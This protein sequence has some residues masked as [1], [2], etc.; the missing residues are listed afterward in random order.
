MFTSAIDKTLG[1]KSGLRS[2]GLAIGPSQY[3][4]ILVRPMFP[5]FMAITH[6]TYLVLK[7]LGPNEVIT[8]KGSFKLLDTCN[9]EFHKMAQTFGM[10]AEYARLKGDIDHNILPN[11][12]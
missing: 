3:H 2:Y 7:I 12:G 1:K 10:I 8:V 6:Y 4:V 11:V 5:R 9:K